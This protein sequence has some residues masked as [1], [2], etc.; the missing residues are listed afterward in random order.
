SAE[1]IEG[2]INEMKQMVID[3]TSIP[4]MVVGLATPEDL[5]NAGLTSTKEPM[6]GGTVIV[7]NVAGTFG[8]AYDDNWGMTSIYKNYR[9]VKVGDSEVITLGRGAI[10][11]SNPS[12]V[13]YEAGVM[14]AGAVFKIEAKKDGWMTIFTRMNPNKQYLVFEGETGAVAYT[15]GVAGDGYKISYTLPSYEEGDNAGL[16]DF[17]SPEA[18]KY[19]VQATKQAVNE[20]GV[21]LWMLENGEVVASDVKPDGGVPVTEEIPGATKPQ[22]PWVIAGMESAPSESTGFLTFRVKEGKT[23]YFGGLGTKAACGGFVFTAGDAAPSVTFCA[24]DNLPKVIFNVEALIS[25]NQAAYEEVI[26]KIEALQKESELAFEESQK[27]N[28]D[29]DF[30][31]WVEIIEGALNQAKE[32]AQQALI[33]ANEEEEEFQFAFDGEEIEAMI[34]EMQMAPLMDKN[35]AAYDLV[36]AQINEVQAYYEDAIA[37]IAEYNPE[38]EI[39]EMKGIIENAISEGKAGAEQALNAAH[40][41]GVE[42]FYPFNAEDIYAM[43]AE[44]KTMAVEGPNQI[45]YAEVVAKIEA[46]EKEYIVV[47]NELKAEYP[48]YDFTE[49]ETIIGGILEETKAGAEMALKSANEDG[50]PFQFAFDG[51][52]VENMIEEMRNDVITSGIGSVNATDNATYYDLNGNKINNPDSGT[53]I[54]IV[55]GKASKVIIK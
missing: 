55:E 42:F 24:T 40:E 43:I 46:V 14:S 25:E 50:D 19:F 28:P 45:A 35:R 32:G 33:V 47:L 3:S 18:S 4:N 53:Y 7:D 17:D 2:M 6:P 15:L 9:D 11:N 49:W 8:L 54:K 48:D 36:I 12:F 51:E 20:E 21:K 16:I 22:F 27:E 38:A 29:Y 44:M 31:E 34:A 30:S 39:T 5:E 37:F 23:Y 1:E 10:G 52:D 13:S 41:D 26:A